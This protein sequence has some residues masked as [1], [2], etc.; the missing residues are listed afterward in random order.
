MDDGVLS[1]VEEEIGH[2][3]WSLHR[4]LVNPVFRDLLDKTVVCSQPA[5]GGRVVHFTS[6]MPT[7]G[8]ATV[9]INN[10]RGKERERERE[11]EI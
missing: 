1:A 2:F 4:V 7:I 11:R 9:V 10:W 5:L 8:R 3:V 6:I